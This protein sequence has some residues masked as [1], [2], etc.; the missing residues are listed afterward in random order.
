MTAI[1][2]ASVPILIPF[3]FGLE[4]SGSVFLAQVLLVGATFSASRRILVEGLQ[5]LGYPQIST[6]AEVSMYPWLLPGG[7]YMT[8]EFGV[9]GLVAA[10]SIGYLISLIVAVIA[11]VHVKESIANSAI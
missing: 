2:I 5:G 10:I 11:T 9:E 4:F 6:Y 1:L 8:M 7:A 3:L